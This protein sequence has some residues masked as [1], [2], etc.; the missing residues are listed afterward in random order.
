M[1][2]PEKKIR[3]VQDI[4]VEWNPLGPRAKSIHDLNEYHTEAIDII[5]QLRIQAIRGFGPIQV[6]QMVLNSAF[7]LNLS[8]SECKKPARKIVAALEQSPISLLET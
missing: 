4:L 3:A 8:R 7:D 2:I 1:S 5:C 6:V